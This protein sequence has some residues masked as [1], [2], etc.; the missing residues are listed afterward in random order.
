MRISLFVFYVVLFCGLVQGQINITAVD[1]PYTQ[2]FDTLAN[3]GT[4]NAWTDNVTLV[5]WYSNRTAYNAGTGSSTTGAM[6]SLGAAASTERALGSL[7]SGTTGTIYYGVRLRN[8]TKNPITS[9]EVTYTGEQWRNSNASPQTLSF[10]YRQAASITDILTGD[11]TA[12]TSLDFTTPTFG[13]TV[14]AI[15]G[16]AKGNRIELNAV[17]SVNIPV[18][19]EIMLRWADIDDSGSDH[20]ISIDDFSVIPLS[21]G[22]TSANLNIEGRVTTADG[23]GIANTSIRIEGGTLSAPLTAITNGFGFFRIEGVPAGH[24]YL[25]SVASRRFVFAEPVRVIMLDDKIGE[26]VFT[27]LP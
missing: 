15:D 2:D 8:D 1:V 9:L 21:A 25:I 13:G 23:R 26:I 3:S 27:A 14:G 24:T 5:G 6:Y 16:N 20:A 22:P 7:A 18:G 4:G 19:E 17:L 11:Y 12:F 10:E